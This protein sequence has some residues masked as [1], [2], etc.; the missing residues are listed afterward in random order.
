ML[1]YLIPIAAIFSGQTKAIVIGAAAWLLMS[2]SYAPMIRFYRL[3]MLW[4]F[5]LPAIAV[6]YAGATFHSAL[7][8]WRGQGG[9]W[10]GRAQDF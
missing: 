6:F 10:K 2:L 5:A 8:Y 3:S 7:Q 4:S 1:T 9:V